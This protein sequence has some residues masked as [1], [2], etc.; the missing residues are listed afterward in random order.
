MA[1]VRD[2]L[3]EADAIAEVRQSLALRIH[4]RKLFEDPTEAELLIK[5]SGGCIRDLMH[6]VTLAFSYTRRA[7]QLTSAA[8]KKAIQRMRAT[9]LRRLTDDD[10]TRLEAIA[11]RE[12]V[13]RDEQ[14]SRLLFYRFALEYLDENDRPWMDVHPLVIETEE[15][16]GVFTSDSPI[17]SS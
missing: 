15:F 13:P 16:R 1:T 12:S 10:Y 6:L 5:M 14:T 11:R 2:S 17:A 9:Y 7:P 3:Y 4:V 8:V